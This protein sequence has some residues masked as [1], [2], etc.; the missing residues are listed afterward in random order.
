MNPVGIYLTAMLVGLL[1]GVHCLTMCGG[2]VSS[3]TLG[4][5]ARARRDPWRLL[6]LQLGYNLGRILGYSFAGALVGGLGAVLLQ[7]DTL[8]IVQRALYGLAA[9]M[10]ILLGLYLGGWWRILRLTERLGLGLWRRLEPLTRRWLPV[11]RVTQ[12]VAIGFFWAWIPCGLVYS[13]LITAMSTGSVGG[14]ALVMI[15]FGAGT[16]PNLLGIGLLAGAAAR[17]AE[18][19]RVRQS[20]GVMV[21]ACGVYGLWQLFS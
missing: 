21:I 8:Q 1:G 14:G 15:A 5:D 7:L 17:L 2:L 3:L 11:R 10:M 13:M 16:L 9:V 18:Q 6:P 20:A 12:A 19:P 4:M